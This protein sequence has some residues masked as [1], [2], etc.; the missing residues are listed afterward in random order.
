MKVIQG[1]IEPAVKYNKFVLAVSISRLNKMKTVPPCNKPNCPDQKG[2]T[3]EEAMLHLEELAPA[4]DC[5]PY[6]LAG[7]ARFYAYR[8]EWVELR[9]LSERLE[10]MGEQS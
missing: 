10:K 9:D 7:L 3:H 5:P 2:P 8:V 6:L 1:F 4:S